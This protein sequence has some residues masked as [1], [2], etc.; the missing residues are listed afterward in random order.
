[1]PAKTTLSPTVMC[2]AR[3]VLERYSCCP[4]DDHALRGNVGHYQAVAAYLGVAKRSLV[5]R[6]IVTHSRMVCVYAQYWH[7]VVY[8]LCISDPAE[9]R[10]SRTGKIRQ[11]LPFEYRP[12]VGIGA[13]QV[14]SPISTSLLGWFQRVYYYVLES[15]PGCGVNVYYGWIILR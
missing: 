14:P 13:Y 8:R 6:F 7:C 4:P 1:M 3:V 15:I 2:P 9:W 5:P 11:F 10:N 12:Y